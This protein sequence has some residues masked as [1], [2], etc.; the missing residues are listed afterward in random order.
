MRCEDLYCRVKARERLKKEGK[1]EQEAKEISDKV[2]NKIKKT[3]DK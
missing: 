1:T 3:W 2:Y